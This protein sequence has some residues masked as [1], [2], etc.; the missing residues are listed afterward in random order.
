MKITSNSTQNRQKTQK[1]QN[2]K[3]LVFQKNRQ[4]MQTCGN[5]VET[6][7]FRIVL[8]ELLETMRKTRLSHKFPHHEIRRN[9]GILRNSL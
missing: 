2:N 9:Y 7:S 8:C 1:A 6:H 5:F 3:K 4:K